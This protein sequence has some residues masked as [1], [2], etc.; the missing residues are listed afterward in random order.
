MATKILR[1]AGTQE[2]V[3]KVKAYATAAAQSA[4]AGI[5]LATVVSELPETGEANKIY[6]VAGENTED[7][8]I[9]TEYVYANNAWE[10]LGEV[11]LDVDLSDYYT[12]EE[13]DAAVTKALNDTLADYAKSTDLSDY[14]KESELESYAK[15]TDLDAYAKETEL[16]D[17]AKKDDLSDFLTESDFEKITADE[18]DAMFE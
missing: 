3:T 11:K 17:Y 2:L 18:I 6:L 1:M 7:N 14:A 9:Y 16:E 15:T 5:E 10:K 12:K 8:N 13:A 4:V